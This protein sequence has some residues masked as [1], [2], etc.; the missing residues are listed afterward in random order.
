MQL[1]L[2]LNLLEQQMR[3]LMSTIAQQITIVQASM[4]AITDLEGKAS[5]VNYFTPSVYASQNAQSDNGAA[6]HRQLYAEKERLSHAQSKI[7]E[8]MNLL[9]SEYVPRITNIM[10]A[11]NQEIADA[12]SGKQ[13][14]EDKTRG[15]YF[16]EG[17]RK[18]HKDLER[19][20]RLLADVKKLASRARQSCQ[21]GGSGGISPGGSIDDVAQN[22]LTDKS[23]TT[24]A[25]YNIPSENYL[26]QQ[27]LTPGRYEAAIKDFGESV[28]YDF[29]QVDILEKLK[30]LFIPRERPKPVHQYLPAL[31][32]TTS[33]SESLVDKMDQFN[34]YITELIQ[35]YNIPPPS[36][37]NR[38]KKKV[39]KSPTDQREY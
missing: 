29:G 4:K 32:K 14:F 31:G 36:F 5:S 17:E 33:S 27:V 18:L 35:H 15:R 21:A 12:K 24:F 34:R 16:D 3:K 1:G 19:C 2:N 20:K 37:Y 28:A 10:N 38:N 6:I 9:H 26:E 8:L 25:S 30:Y 23:E 22:A 11:V 13:K 7:S 39:Y